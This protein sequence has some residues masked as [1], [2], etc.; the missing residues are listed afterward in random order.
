MSDFL[1]RLKTAAEAAATEWKPSGY[2]IAG[3]QIVCS[4]CGNTD[5]AEGRAHTT[6]SG[7]SFAGIDWANSTATTL[8]CVACSHIEWFHDR[9]EKTTT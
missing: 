9:P 1:K 8:S 6:S 5:F 7:M 4:H 2:T 3:R